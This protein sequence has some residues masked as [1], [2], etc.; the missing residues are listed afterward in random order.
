MRFMQSSCTWHSTPWNIWTTRVCKSCLQCICQMPP[1]GLGQAVNISHKGCHSL[2]VKHLRAF[3]VASNSLEVSIPSHSTV[4]KISISFDSFCLCYYS[5]IHFTCLHM[6]VCTIFSS[7][8]R[9][10]KAAIQVHGSTQGN[11]VVSSSPQIEINS[12]FLR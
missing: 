9:I 4:G 3:W 11:F 8:W 10:S 12:N 6:S 7:S 1:R 2:A 5:F